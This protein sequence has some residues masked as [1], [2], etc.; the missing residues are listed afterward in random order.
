[1]QNRQVELNDYV[2]PIMRCRGRS[3]SRLCSLLCAAGALRGARDLL[4]SRS[5]PVTRWTRR[6]R[7]LCRSPPPVFEEQPSGT[8]G[9][10]AHGSPV[11]GGG[12]PPIGEATARGVSEASWRTTRTTRDHYADAGRLYELEMLLNAFAI[13]SRRQP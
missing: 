3:R 11:A 6:S 2:K 1:M 12:A 5:P 8:V 10:S 7:R 4:S 13:A 9:L